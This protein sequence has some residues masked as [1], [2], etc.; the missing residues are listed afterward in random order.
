MRRVRA[1]VAVVLALC[2]CQVFAQQTAQEQAVWKM[3]H[4]YWEDVKAADLVSYRALWHPN[5]LGWPRSSAT[6]ARK[7]HITDWITNNAAKGIHLSGYTLKPAASQATGNLVVTDYWVTMDWVDKNG[8]RK[9]ERDR[10]THTWMR[11]GN[12][13]EIISGMSCPVSAAG[14]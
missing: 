13:W 4:K 6:P 5:F 9:L 10:I 8:T 14:K 1:L 12:R 7:A 11:V 2:A 3:E